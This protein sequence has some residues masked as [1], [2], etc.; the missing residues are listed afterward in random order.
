M[1]IGTAGLVGAGL[2]IVHGWPPHL[3]CD[4]SMARIP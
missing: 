3:E 2:L 4:C 1:F